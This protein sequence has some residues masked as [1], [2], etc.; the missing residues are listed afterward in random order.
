MEKISALEVGHPTEVVRE[1][2]KGVLDY[3]AHGL[4]GLYLPDDF[5]VRHPNAYDV[6]S[7]KPEDRLL[8][9]FG[10]FVI[11][12]YT[13]ND[14]EEPLIDDE[15]TPVDIIVMGTTIG[16]GSRVRYG[17]MSHLIHYDLG[18]MAL[19][20]SKNKKNNRKADIVCIPADY[21]LT[22]IGLDEQGNP[23]T[24]LVIAK[25]FDFGRASTEE[26][27]RTCKL[28][29]ELLG[30]SIKVVNGTPEPIADDKIIS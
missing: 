18:E 14:E 8:G 30:D 16:L 20:F 7:W 27:D 6:K 11:S 26:R 4:S 13:Y 5:K 19:A 21:G 1:V 3:Y 17:E 12:K 15:F 23:Q 25:S 24:L 2:E 28:F 22:R 29:Q 10:R 9:K